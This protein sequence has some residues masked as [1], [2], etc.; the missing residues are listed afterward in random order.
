[1][2]F[3]FAK[4]SFLVREEN[5]ALVDKFLICEEKSIYKIVTFY[6]IL[7]FYI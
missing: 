3:L 5:D 4:E 2:N 6:K 7:L 1:M